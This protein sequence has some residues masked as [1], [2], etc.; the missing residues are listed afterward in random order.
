VTRIS[1][2]LVDQAGER[3]A[4]DRPG[5]LLSLIMSLSISLSSC[6]LHTSYSVS[7]IST[8]STSASLAGF[9]RVIVLQGRSPPSEISGLNGLSLSFPFSVSCLSPAGT[10]MV[11][12]GLVVPIYFSSTVLLDYALRTSF[13]S[14][15][16]PG[17]QHCQ[18]FCS[19]VC[20]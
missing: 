9:V 17:D 19:I 14:F 3:P 15:Q 16:R 7:Y 4:E 13:F 12:H 11:Q 18:C 6:Q 1:I 2:G 20:F 8:H 10:A 5:P